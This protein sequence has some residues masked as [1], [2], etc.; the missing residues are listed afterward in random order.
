MKRKLALVVVIFC[1]SLFFGCRT[2]GIGEGSE[3]TTTPT[4]LPSDFS[5]I[6][7]PKELKLDKKSSLLFEGGPYKSG[8]F[9]YK[10]RVEASSLAE[11]FKNAL[12]GYGWVLLNNFKYR[13]YLL[14]FIKEKEQRSCII[15]IEEGF[16]TTKVHLWVGPT[17]GKL[18]GS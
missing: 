18:K 3:K 4:T 16:W 12:Q 5:D 7:I 6:P 9:V 17:E 11:Y 2:L 8:Y 10:G 13:H 1:L 14:N 15:L